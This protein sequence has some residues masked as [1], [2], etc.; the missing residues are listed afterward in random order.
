LCCLF[1]IETIGRN[2][3]AFFLF[4]LV[5]PPDIKGLFLIVCEVKLLG[6]ENGDRGSERKGGSYIGSKIFSLYILNFLNLIKIQYNP[7]L[8]DLLS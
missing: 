7:P 8:S 5:L 1:V 6:M 2:D 3:P 4:S